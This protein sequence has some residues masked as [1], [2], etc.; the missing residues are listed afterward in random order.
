MNKAGALFVSDTKALPA[1]PKKKAEGSLDF[2][3]IDDNDDDCDVADPDQ[4]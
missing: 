4:A 3:V 2:T 1:P